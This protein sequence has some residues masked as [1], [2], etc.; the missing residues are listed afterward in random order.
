MAINRPDLQPLRVSERTLL[1]RLKKDHAANI[2]KVDSII[3]SSAFPTPR[4]LKHASSVSSEVTAQNSKRIKI[5]EAARRNPNSKKLPAATNVVCTRATTGCKGKGTSIAALKIVSPK[6]NVAEDGRIPVNNAGST[7]RDMNSCPGSNLHVRFTTKSN[8][9]QLETGREVSEASEE[10]R[11]ETN[12]FQ[13]AQLAKFQSANEEVLTEEI[14]GSPVSMGQGTLDRP[15]DFKV[16][17]LHS[18]ADYG[19]LE[20]TAT[21]FQQDHICRVTTDIHHQGAQSTTEQLFHELEKSVSHQSE[22]IGITENGRCSKCKI[23]QWNREPKF[24]SCVKDNGFTFPEQDDHAHV[25]YEDINS[26]Q[27]LNIRKG[28]SAANTRLY[29]SVTHQSMTDSS[30]THIE[31]LMVSLKIPKSTW[32]LQKSS[33]RKVKPS[34]AQSLSAGRLLLK[35]KPSSIKPKSEN[36]KYFNTFMPITKRAAKNSSTAKSPNYSRQRSCTELQSPNSQQTTKEVFDLIEVD[37]ETLNF[38]RNLTAHMKMTRE[39]KPDPLGQPLVWADSRQALCETV[40]YFKK[41]QGGCHQNDRHVYAFLFDGVG[42]C[43]EY[44]DNDVIIA[45]AGGSMEPDGSGTMIQA[46]HQSMSDAQ[47]QAVMND[48]ELQNPLI[49]ICGDKNTA[50]PS[51][52]PHKYCVLGWYKP[53]LI[54]AEKTAGR[55]GKSWTTVKFRFERLQPEKPA[56]HAPKNMGGQR[57]Y[58]MSPARKNVCGKCHKTSPQVYLLFWSCLNP[59]CELFWKLASGVDAPSGTLDYDP[60]FLLARNPW[61]NEEEP[62]NVKPPLPDIGNAIGDN[63]SYI[64]TR[65]ICCPEC[66]RC[67]H[68]YLFR[69]WRCDNPKCSWEWYPEHRPIL[70]TALHQPWDTFG[71]GPSLGR[72]K[73]EASVKLEVSY[74]KGY[75]VYKYTFDGIEGN[76]VHAIANNKINRE[77]RAADEMLIAMQTEDMRLQRRRFGTEK[78]SG[79]K[80]DR[81]VLKTPQRPAGS[82]QLPTPDESLRRS[83]QCSL[84]EDFTGISQQSTPDNVNIYASERVSFLPCRSLDVAHRIALLKGPDQIPRCEEPILLTIQDKHRRETEMPEFSRNTRERTH[85]EKTLAQAAENT[86]KSV[87]SIATEATKTVTRDHHKTPPAASGSEALAQQPLDFDLSNNIPTASIE[88]ISSEPE[89]RPKSNSDGNSDS[90]LQT[91]GSE[92]E[93]GDFMTAFSVNYGMPYKFVSSV[94]SL[95]FEEAP[96]PVTECRSRLNWA[97]RTFLDDRT[98]DADFNEALILAYMEGQKMEYHDDG[99][100][101]LGPRIATLSLGGKAKMHVRMKMKHYTGCSK[102]GIFTPE[103]PVPGGIGGKDMDKRRLAEWEKLQTLKEVDRAAY[104][105]RLKEIPRE[106]G[107]FEKRMKKADDLVTVSLS[108]GDIILMEGY[109]IQKYLEHKVVAKGYLRFALTCRTVLANHLKPEELPKYEVRP[110]SHYYQGPED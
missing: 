94:A 21:V 15:K 104:Q 35:K 45:R 63:L 6:S 109:D 49:I 83:A 87:T 60:A 102:S 38:S 18:S 98:L 31:R 11:L 43:R 77:P 64:N 75:K 16:K 14:P 62:F 46:K 67:N 70:P 42:H 76:F 65:G 73:H 12:S 108:H 29:N 89:Y 19:I 25:V 72:N 24:Q 26:A 40:P 78:M 74:V 27:S 50:S 34:S 81:V 90:N 10:L 68:R 32:I 92:I 28:K 84:K 103:R 80:T 9:P 53:I 61:P 41:P 52:I 110:D 85:C 71:D 82:L 95:P 44:M 66:G 106:L 36:I 79:S 2:D 96:W 33:K 17:C 93:S 47:V 97:A 37:T 1:T 56:W 39:Q 55:G 57:Q 86:L 69:G 88:S 4:K 51:K 23:L 91:K 58:Q 99:E 100:E 8:G 20:D 13:D 59:Q 48:I 107:L 54:W 105:A 7:A 22:S 5:S 101:G 30:K 3:S